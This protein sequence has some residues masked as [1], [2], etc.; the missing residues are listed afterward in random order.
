MVKNSEKDIDEMIGIDQDE[1]DDVIV[2]TD[3]DGKEHAFYEEQQF[4]VGGNTYAVLV[5]LKDDA[6][7]CGD[8]NCHCHESN[9]DMAAI[10]A[11]VEFDDDGNPVYVEPSEKEFEEASAAYQAIENGY[12]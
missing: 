1:F 11:K 8:D 12:D 3:D 10:L 2:F 6:C 5:G 9:E 7:V 4:I